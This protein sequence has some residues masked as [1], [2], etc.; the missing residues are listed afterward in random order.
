MMCFSSRHIS[1]GGATDNQ[2]SLICTLGLAEFHT[3]PRRHPDT[4]F[5]PVIILSGDRRM[6]TQTWF[7]LWRNSE[8][9]A[10][11]FYRGTYMKLIRPPGKG[12]LV[13]MRQSC[14]QPVYRSTD[15]LCIYFG[16][17]TALQT[18][19]SLQWIFFFLFDELQQILVPGLPQFQEWKVWAG[20]WHICVSAHAQQLLCFF[21]SSGPELGACSEGG[22]TG[23]GHAA[24]TQRT[25]EGLWRGLQPRHWR[26]FIHWTPPACR[27]VNTTIHLC[28]GNEID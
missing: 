28:Y 22:R 16:S 5:I 19:T 9:A 13:A 2:L 26:I 20:V 4:T 18:A 14:M 11:R 17:K 8:T 27:L 3:R 12:T 25:T 21:C 15:H 1:P 24:E 7:H 23:A 6:K 10:W